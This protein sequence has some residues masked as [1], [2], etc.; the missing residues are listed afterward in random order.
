LGGI[1]ALIAQIIGADEEDHMRRAGLCQRIAIEAPQ[2]AFAAHLVE[3]AVAADALVHD[4][5]AAAIARREPPR[6]LV[7]PAAVRIEARE[8]AFGQRIA[9]ADDAAG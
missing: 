1:A 9:E 2:P 4:A 3:D 6:E 7:G 8:I 5:E